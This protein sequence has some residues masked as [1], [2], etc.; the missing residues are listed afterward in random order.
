[1]KKPYYYDNI[2]EYIVI[3]LTN[4]FETNMSICE[5]GFSGGHF[6]VELYEKGYKNLAGIEIRQA[7][8]SKTLEKFKCEKI[9]VEL[10]QGDVL[11]N[12]NKYDGIYSTGLLQC[13]DRERRYKFIDHLSKM[14]EKAVFVVPEIEEDRNQDSD[15]LVAVSGCKEYKTGTLAYELSEKYDV[16]RMGKIDKVKVHTEENFIYYICENKEQN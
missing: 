14:A 5:I 10:I 16:V 8:Y 15:Q 13:M 4:A 6:L 2:S 12:N 7:Q 3:L 1:M 11:E 9:E